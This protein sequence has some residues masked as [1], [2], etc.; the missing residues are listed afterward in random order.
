VGR[1][2]RSNVLPDDSD[3]TGFLARMAQPLLLVG[4]WLFP[5]FVVFAIEI[6]DEFSHK[7]MVSPETFYYVMLNIGNGCLLFLLWCTKQSDDELGR[8]HHK[9][10]LLVSELIP[11]IF[12]ALLPEY[13]SDLNFFPEDTLFIGGLLLFILLPMIFVI[14]HL[15]LYGIP[16]R[17]QIK[18]QTFDPF[19][20][21]KLEDQYDEELRD[22]EEEEDREFRAQMDRL[23]YLEDL[24]PSARRNRKNLLAQRK[25]ATI[26]IAVFALVLLIA[27]GPGPRDMVR[28]SKTVFVK[29]RF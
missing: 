22:R 14:T 20:F 19:G 9:K 28:G 8:H 11:T 18:M 1:W 21:K 15:F 16:R 26:L 12:F 4:L 5:V 24:V 29:H 17:I 6:F 23:A 10:Q 13:A 25:A 7:S 3:P 2:V 27:S